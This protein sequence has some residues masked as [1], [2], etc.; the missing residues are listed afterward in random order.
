VLAVVK[1]SAATAANS[2]KTAKS[3]RS[4]INR[5]SSPHCDVR[6]VTDE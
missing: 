6:E 2:A 4:A 5:I 1:A 3:L